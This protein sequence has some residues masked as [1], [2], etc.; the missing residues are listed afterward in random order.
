MRRSK[1]VVRYREA[2][3]VLF[4]AAVRIAIVALFLAGAQGTVRAQGTTVYRHDEVSDYDPTFICQ[5]TRKKNIAD[6]IAAKRQDPY[7]NGRQLG[8]ADFSYITDCTNLHQPDYQQCI[9]SMDPAGC[10]SGAQAKAKVAIVWVLLLDKGAQGTYRLHRA[11][12]ESPV[13]AVISAQGHDPPAQQDI[14]RCLQW[15]RNF[16]AALGQR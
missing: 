3:E 6:C 14:R 10:T 11:K 7:N 13:Q 8:N 1:E 2:C 12:G 4:F 5:Q 16:I 9:D 15:S